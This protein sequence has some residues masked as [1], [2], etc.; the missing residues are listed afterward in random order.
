MWTCKWRWR[1]TWTYSQPWSQRERTARCPP[2]VE[3]N[4]ELASEYRHVGNCVSYLIYKDNSGRLNMIGRERANRALIG[5]DSQW[6]AARWR[7]LH[8][9]LIGSSPSFIHSCPLRNAIYIG[10]MGTC[11][12]THIRTHE[13]ANKYIIIFQMNRFDQSIRTDVCSSGTW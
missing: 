7:A 2:V 13:S 10:L 12:A 6:N 3:D 4:H 8:L 1:W 9:Y 5:C 11:K